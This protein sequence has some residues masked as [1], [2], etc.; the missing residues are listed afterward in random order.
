MKV[1]QLVGA[2]GYCPVVASLFNVAN[3]SG[4]ASAA[5]TTAVSCVDQYG[6][7]ALPAN[8]AYSVHVTP[9]QA[10]VFAS[11]TNKTASGFTVTL[12]PLSGGSV[13]AGSFDALV[14]A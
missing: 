10:S 14:H 13:A 4:S 6:V 2:N 3:A 5:V 8:G 9:N 12:T 1:N 7:G 11:V